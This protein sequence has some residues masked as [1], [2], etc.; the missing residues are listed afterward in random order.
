MLST[1]IV[2]GHGS[3]N[4]AK[5][6]GEGE[7][8]VAVHPHPPIDEKTF[9][10]PFVQS[11]T[12]D[13]LADG[14]TDM[15]VDGSSTPV[16]FYINAIGD[17]DLYIKLIE[18]TI[19]DAGATLSKFGNLTALTNGCDMEWVTDD[20]GTTIIKSGMKSNWDFVKLAKGQPAFGDAA[21]AFRAGNVVSTSEAYIPVVDM[22]YLFGSQW[23]LRLRK[24]TNDRIII[25]IND[26]LNPGTPVDE[27][28]AE[29]TGI[30]F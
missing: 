13:G 1:Q 23:G 26:D 12:D 16:E 10:I 22:A 14:A 11:I 21:G 30:K 2:D 20:L 3:G 17:Q 19:A 15:R 29:C 25:R 24:G 9:G 18:I 7:F 8:T 27:F 6:N 4:R 28:T 5:V